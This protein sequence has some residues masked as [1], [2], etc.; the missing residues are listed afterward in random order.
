MSCM[1]HISYHNTT[2]L[3]WWLTSPASSLTRWVSEGCRWVMGVGDMCEGCRWVTGAGGMCEGCRWV[4]GA[5][6]V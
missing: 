4:K 3:F 2:N 6:G 5:W 1:L